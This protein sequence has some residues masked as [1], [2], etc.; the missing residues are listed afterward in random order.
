MVKQEGGCLYEEKTREFPEPE[1]SGTNQYLQE[2][3]RFFAE[4][5]ATY[6]KRQQEPEQKSTDLQKIQT[7]IGSQ[8]QSLKGQKQ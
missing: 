2:M 8:Y 4:R 1:G 6:Q 3:Q 5:E 7:E